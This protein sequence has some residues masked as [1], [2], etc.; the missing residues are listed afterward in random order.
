MRVRCEGEDE[1]EGEG[2]GGRGGERRQG[3]CDL[4]EFGQRVLLGCVVQLAKLGELEKLQ[5]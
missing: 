4:L 2:E 5:V 1:G 3:G